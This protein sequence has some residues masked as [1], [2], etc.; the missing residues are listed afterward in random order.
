MTYACILLPYPPSLNS[1]WRQ[2]KGRTHKSTKYT[3]WIVDAGYALNQ[4]RPPHL[5]PPYIVEIAAG[6]PDKRKRDLDNLIK[7][8]LDLLTSHGVI[9]DD[10]EIEHLTIYWATDDEVQNGVRVEVKSV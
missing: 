1:N 2:G 7:P 3:L 8:V 5:S 9:C 6:R 4:Q 10:S